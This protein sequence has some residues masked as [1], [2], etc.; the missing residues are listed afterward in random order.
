MRFIE[1]RLNLDE[2]QKAK[3]KQLREKEFAGMDSLA[4][5]RFQAMRDLYSLLKTENPG[6]E[7]IQ[8]KAAAIGAVETE[9]SAS[10]F[11]HFQELRSL[12]TPEQQKEFDKIVTDAMIQARGGKTGPRGP[13]PP[14]PGFDGPGMPPDGGGMPP[15]PGASRPP[16]AP[17]GGPNGP[18][19]GPREG[20]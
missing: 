19:G 14:G 9:Q 10:M 20:K 15:L 3:F 18:P 11:R 13:E 4:H 17:Q 16:D 8:Q 12:C 2:G 1:E 5:R 6:P 7:Q